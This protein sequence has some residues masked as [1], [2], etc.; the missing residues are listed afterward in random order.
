MAIAVIDPLQKTAGKGA[1]G[2]VNDLFDM[3][4]GRDGVDV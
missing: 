4:Y 3:G 1:G 2:Q